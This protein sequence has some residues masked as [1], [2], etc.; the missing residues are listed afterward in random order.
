MTVKRLVVHVLDGRGNRIEQLLVEAPLIV[1]FRPR[2]FSWT[3]ATSAWNASRFAL[4][5]SSSA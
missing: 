3:G 2:N 5:F 1:S 4:A